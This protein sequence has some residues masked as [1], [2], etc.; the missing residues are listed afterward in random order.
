MTLAKEV[1]HF[2]ETDTTPHTLAS[3][4]RRDCGDPKGTNQ[5]PPFS[6]P[7]KV[8]IDTAAAPFIRSSLAA[9]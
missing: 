5:M 9:L 7:I 8:R 6:L 2:R 3:P 1:V 4:S